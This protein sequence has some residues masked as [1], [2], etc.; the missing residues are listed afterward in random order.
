MQAVTA[1]VSSAATEVKAARAD[2]AG[3]S[4]AAKSDVDATPSEPAVEIEMTG[5]L[6]EAQLQAKA[7]AP[8]KQRL[9]A[10]GLKPSEVDLLLSLY[11]KAF[12]QSIEPVLLARL[13]QATIDDLL[14]LEVD[15]D[16]AKI[17]RVALVLCFKIDP[18]IRD[19]VKTLV[20][21][22]ADNSYEK[23]EQ[24]ETKLRDLGRMAIPALKQAAKSDDPEQ[25]MRAERLLLRQGEKL[26]GK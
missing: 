16:T 2:K 23:R 6:D 26:E 14:P 1:A 17:S 21:Q 15:P 13:P 12:F 10:A 4:D 8:L 25:V 3:K 18:Q 24:A 20:A 5:P 9:S 11:T 22:L 7:V 19:Q